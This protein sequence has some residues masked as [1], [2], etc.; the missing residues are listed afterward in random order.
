MSERKIWNS[1]QKK[2]K[3]ELGVRG[4]SQ[5]EFARWI[6]WRQTELNRYLTGKNQPGIDKIAE[7][8]G[9]LDWSLSELFAEIPKIKVKPRPLSVAEQVQL[10]VR[11]ELAKRSLW[12]AAE[13]EPDELADKLRHLS[14]EHREA[15]LSVLER[16][17]RM[18]ESK[19]K[20]A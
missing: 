5:A 9:G 18:T 13:Q 17:S 10:A 15:M 19:K 12:K 8:A 16:V 2:I 11:E 6:G 1:L 14:P 20:K 4:V 3:D 7:I